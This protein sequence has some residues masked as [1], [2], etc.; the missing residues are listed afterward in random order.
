MI[1]R[2]VLD[3]WMNATNEEAG[4]GYKTC[5]LCRHVIYQCRRYNGILHRIRNDVEQIKAKVYGDPK[6]ILQLQ[7]AVYDMLF[8]EGI[9][10][11]RFSETKEYLA[12]LLLNVTE[13]GGVT[14]LDYNEVQLVVVLCLILNG[15]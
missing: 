4:L 11:N 6:E 12:K 5:P 7:K 14:N 9:E 13:A 3:G 10:L 1:E 15:G 2:E 8:V